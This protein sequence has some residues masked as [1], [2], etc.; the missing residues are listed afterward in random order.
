[1]KQ[2]GIDVTGYFVLLCKFKQLCFKPPVVVKTSAVITF[3]TY[4]GR[5]SA[6]WTYAH[7]C[8]SK[9]PR[10]GIEDRFAGDGK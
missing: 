10:V 7:Q 1:M 8:A 9:Y 6:C 4:D 3:D 5:L 2:H